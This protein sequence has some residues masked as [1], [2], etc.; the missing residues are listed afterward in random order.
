VDRWFFRAAYVNDS[1]GAQ[2]TVPGKRCCGRGLLR[3][4]SPFHLPKCTLF[5]IAM[6]HLSRKCTT[7]AVPFTM[8]QTSRWQYRHWWASTLINSAQWGHFFMV[9]P[10]FGLVASPAS[11]RGDRRTCT[12]AMG[13]IQKR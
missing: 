2:A 11:L 9:L 3:E 6:R 10:P 1:V 4:P 5:L 8:G 13:Q 12:R 7:V